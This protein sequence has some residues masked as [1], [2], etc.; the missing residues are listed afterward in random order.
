MSQGS[1]FD[2][3]MPAHRPLFNACVTTPTPFALICQFNSEHICPGTDTCRRAVELFSKAAWVGMVSERQIPLTE[4][5][6][7]RRLSNALV[8]RN[9]VNLEETEVLVPWPN[10]QTT[11]MAT[12]ARL[13]V[14]YKG[15]DVLL[16]SLGQPPWPDRDWELSFLAMARTWLT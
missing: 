5:Q 9:P 10:S 16:E 12:V 13:D 1:T 14:T 15:Q 8:L 4:R 7:A 2:T 6:L 11:K 3:C